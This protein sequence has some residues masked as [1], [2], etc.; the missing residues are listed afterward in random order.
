MTGTATVV[1][2]ARNAAATLMRQL[3]ALE[4][5]IGDLPFRVILVDNG[6]TDGTGD[7]ARAFPATRFDIVVVEEERPGINCARNRGIDAAPEG[8]VLL[9]DADDEVSP[10]WL[11]AMHAALTGR[12]WVAGVVDYTSLNDELTRTQWGAEERSS[13]ETPEPF[14]DRTFG[15]NC[16][17]FK[18]MWAEVG[19]FDDRLSGIGG[20][21]SRPFALFVELLLPFFLLGLAAVHRRSAG[22]TARPFMLGVFYAGLVILSVPA[23]I[24]VTAFGIFEQWGRRNQPPGGKT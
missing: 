6:S 16:G 12:T 8:A 1:I 23:A 15:C 22:R 21:S 5:Q 13:C 9:C 18:S 4:R 19:R 2:P 20:E 17:F 11:V 3:E 10:G 24:A 7:L 14:I